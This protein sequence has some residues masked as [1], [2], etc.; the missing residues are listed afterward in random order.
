MGRSLVVLGMALG[1]FLAAAPARA[2]CLRYE[3]HPATLVGTVV[4]RRLPGPPGYRDVARG[5]YPETVYFLELDEPVCV[6]GDRSS[7]TNRKS[8]ADVGEVQISA[9]GPDLRRYRGKK[10]RATGGLFGAHMPYHRTPVVFDV[11][12]VR[13]A[14]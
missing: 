12:T 8:H 5:D 11:K 6:T 1:A 2:Q 3:P 9:D 13:P 4:A 10:V 14:P 7:R